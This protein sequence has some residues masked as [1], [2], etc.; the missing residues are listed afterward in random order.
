MAFSKAEW[1]SL[2]NFQQA[3]FSKR[4]QMS[5]LRDSI[6][7][8]PNIFPKSKLNSSE[9]CLPDCSHPE[10]LSLMPSGKSTDKYFADKY[11]ALACVTGEMG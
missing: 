2:L 9:N 3:M 7:P 4:N 10:C 1:A 11:F 5:F 8:G 6:F